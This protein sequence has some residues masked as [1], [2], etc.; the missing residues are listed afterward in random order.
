MSQYRYS[1]SL[2]AYLLVLFAAWTHADSGKNQKFAD[3][4]A[5]GKENQTRL[6]IMK[7]R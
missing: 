6:R 7:A 4:A 1:A 3:R 5:Y 2:V